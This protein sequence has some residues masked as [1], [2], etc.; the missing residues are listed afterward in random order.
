M[1]NQNNLGILLVIFGV[2]TSLGQPE[3]FNLNILSGIVGID[4]N[5]KQ[6]KQCNIT[7]AGVVVRRKDSLE[8]GNYHNLK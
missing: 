5:N 8:L 3:Q 1:D 2:V 6:W 4:F 7:R